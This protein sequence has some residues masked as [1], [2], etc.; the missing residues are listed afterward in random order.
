MNVILRATYFVNKNA[1]L[2]TNTADVGPQTRLE[3]FRDRPMPFFGAENN[4]NEVLA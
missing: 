3:I 2:P 4:M 1:F